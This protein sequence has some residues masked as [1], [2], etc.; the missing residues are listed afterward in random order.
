VRTANLARNLRIA[1]NQT[2]QEPLD[3][4]WIEERTFL[5]DQVNEIVIKECKEEE[6]PNCAICLENY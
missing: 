1:D 5:F 3:L 2:V 4:N 6:I